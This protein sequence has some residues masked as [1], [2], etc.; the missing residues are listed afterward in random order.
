MMYASQDV[1]MRDG[2]GTHSSI[3][4]VI[5][6]GESV[7]VYS[8]SDGWSKI[9]KTIRLAM[10]MPVIYLKKNHHLMNKEH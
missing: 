10:L 8:T 9:K 6:R 3:I 1:N 7:K 4:M 5:F 2:A